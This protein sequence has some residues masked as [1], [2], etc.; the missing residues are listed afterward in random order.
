MRDLEKES[1]SGIMQFIWEQVDQEEIR[2]IEE[3]RLEE[4]VKQKKYTDNGVRQ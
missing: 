4:L 3:D 2:K 1:L